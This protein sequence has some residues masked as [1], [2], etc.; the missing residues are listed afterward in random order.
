V[1][2]HY[3]ITLQHPDSLAE[4]P[5]NLIGLGLLPKAAHEP[6]AVSL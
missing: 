3:D 6:M 5:I 4:K 2:A 1:A